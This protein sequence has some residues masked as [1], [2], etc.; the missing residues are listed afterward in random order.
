MQTISGGTVHYIDVDLLPYPDDPRAAGQCSGPGTLALL[1]NG[2]VVEAF[3]VTPRDVMLV[4][5]GDVV[6]PGTELFARH[7]GTRWLRAAIPHG[8]EVIAVWSERLDEEDDP[9]TGLKRWRFRRHRTCTGRRDGARS[10]RGASARHGGARRHARDDEPGT[11]RIRR[12]GATARRSPH[13]AAALTIR[14]K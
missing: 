11:A 6:A 10:A 7:F 5:D 3:A 1:W 8:S 13:A 9:D 14:T 4:A 2:R 12:D